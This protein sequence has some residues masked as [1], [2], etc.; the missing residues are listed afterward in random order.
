MRC[1]EERVYLTHVGK[2]YGMLTGYLIVG[3]KRLHMLAV[4]VGSQVS[5]AVC[6]SFG[7]TLHVFDKPN[8]YFSQHDVSI[9]DGRGTGPQT[10]LTW[11][12]GGVMML[13]VL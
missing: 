1:H 3:L 4:C 13:C 6:C 10:D 8:I 11:E 5:N 9:Q 2:P 12:G 7:F